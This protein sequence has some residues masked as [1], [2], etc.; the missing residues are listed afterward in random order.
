VGDD[1]ED[2]KATAAKNI[3][4]AKLL[5]QDAA[6]MGECFQPALTQAAAGPGTDAPG[7]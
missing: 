7:D 1:I 4:A 6:G 2:V 5:G 3:P